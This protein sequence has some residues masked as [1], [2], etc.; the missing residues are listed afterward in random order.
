MSRS[1]A[2]DGDALT[3]QF[4]TGIAGAVVMS[5]ALALGSAGG[6]DLF[7]P[8][9]PSSGAMLLLVGMGCVATVGHLL[10]TQAFRHAPAGLLAPFQYLEIV[11]ATLLGYLLFDDLPDTATVI[12]IAI[13]VGSGL[14]VFHRERRISLAAPRELPVP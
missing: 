5:L 10:L 14:Y 4:T 11:S 2:R 9:M 8:V 6:I 12:G 1:L 13:I 3:M 7:T